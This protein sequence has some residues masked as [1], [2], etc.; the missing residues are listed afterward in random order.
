MC[1]CILG[2]GALHQPPPEIDETVLKVVALGSSC[3]PLRPGPA[4]SISLRLSRP[5][6]QVLLPF[7]TF[8]GD[9]GGGRDVT[10]RGG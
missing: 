5:P 1:R 9:P 6:G 4:E 2:A 7:V 3:E 10:F 8:Y